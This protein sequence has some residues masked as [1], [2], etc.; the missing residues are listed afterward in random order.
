MFALALLIL[1]NSCFGF[2]SLRSLPSDELPRPLLTL[3]PLPLLRLE[4]DFGLDRLNKVLAKWDGNPSILTLSAFSDAGRKCST[5]CRKWV[6]YDVN[7]FSC[8]TLFDVSL[9]D[10]DDVDIGVAFELS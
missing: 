7:N 1:F 6:G 10:D 4:S 2:G 9:E 5:V 8:M 3:D